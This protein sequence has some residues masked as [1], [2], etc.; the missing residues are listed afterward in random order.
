MPSIL[1]R[2]EAI[3]ERLN[4]IESTLRVLLEQQEEEEN[5]IHD[6]TA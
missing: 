2:L 3:E 6:E 1:D 4:D 5:A